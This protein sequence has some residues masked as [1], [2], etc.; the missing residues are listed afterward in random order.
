MKNNLNFSKEILH[1]IEHDNIELANKKLHKRIPKYIYKF[2][3]LGND[4]DEN[5]IKK[6]NENKIFFNASYKM[7]DKTEYNNTKIIVN[8]KTSS[9]IAE[10]IDMHQKRDRI[11]TCFTYGK[12]C[13]NNEYMWKEY[14]NNS[15]GI[16]CKF[17]V[18]DKY[19]LFPILYSNIEPVIRPATSNDDDENNKLFKKNSYLFN[20]I[21]TIL[22]KEEYSNENEIRMFSDIEFNIFCCSNKYISVIKAL[23]LEEIYL[24][25]NCSSKNKNL[26]K[27]KFSG[28]QIK[29]IIC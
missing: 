15:Q 9:D 13:I 17:K 28:I 20:I 29:D 16:L 2:F 25:I 4:Y 23:K 19:I 3:S 7:K 1:L 12:N 27:N 14:A 21:N 26:I 22:K 6:L 18:L 24:G 11:F 8:C 5:L 10:N